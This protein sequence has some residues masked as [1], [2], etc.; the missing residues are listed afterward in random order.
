MSE[1]CQEDLLMLKRFQ[2][3]LIVVLLALTVIPSLLLVNRVEAQFTLGTNWVGTFYNNADLA[4]TPVAQNIPYPY[5]LC[6]VW[7]GAPTSGSTNAGQPCLPGTPVT[8]VNA[9]NFS[10]I[11]TST[12]TLAQA[13]NYLFTVRHNDGVRVNINNTQYLNAWGPIVPETT[14]DCANRCRQSTFTVNLPAGAVS[15]RVEFQDI[16]GDAILQFQYNFVGGTGGVTPGATSFI[17]TTTAVPAATGQVVRVRGLALRTGPYLGASYV[18]A[19]VPGISYP[20]LARNNDE[21]LFTWYK[22]TV[23]DN[24]GWVSGRYFQTTG[25]VDAIPFEGTV[26]DQIDNEGEKGITGVTRSVMNLRRRPSERAT[27]LDK[28]PWGA[29]VPIIGRTVQGGNNFWLQVRYNGKVGWIFAPFVG[30]RGLIEA[31]PIR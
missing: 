25:N 16:S 30:I 12:Q 17:P 22:I 18:G 3:L 29:E 13:G 6:G 19:A 5:G 11:F 14:G 1:Y 20:L 23:G 24:T 7:S 28:V 26:F 31:V 27:L 21:G 10:A 8:G 9:D 15:M 2:F 4:G